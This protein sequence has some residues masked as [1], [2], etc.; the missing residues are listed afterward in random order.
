MLSNMNGLSFKKL[1]VSMAVPI[2]LAFSSISQAAEPL[3]VAYSDWPD[4]VAWQVAIDKG[5]FKEAGLDIK[6]ESVSYT[7]LT[8]PTNREE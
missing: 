3:K 7:H 6:F 2:T 5:W 1:I 4:F 8:L